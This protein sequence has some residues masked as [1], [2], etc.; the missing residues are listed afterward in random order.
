M[1]R[2]KK[3]ALSIILYKFALTKQTL[4][5]QQPTNEKGS[6]DVAVYAGEAAV[7]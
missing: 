3:F 7:L 2:E 4:V 5:S 1:N 6:N